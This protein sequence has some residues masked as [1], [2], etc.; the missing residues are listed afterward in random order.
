MN[1]IKGND[2]YYTVSTLYALGNIPAYHGILLLE[3]IYA[4]IE[5]IYQILE[6]YLLRN[7]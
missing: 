1:Y 5:Y 4:Q 6:V 2:E 7:R 3:G